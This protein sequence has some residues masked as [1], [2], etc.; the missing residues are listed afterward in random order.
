MTMV[1]ILIANFTIVQNQKY[2]TY[3]NAARGGLSHGHRTCTKKL[4][5]IGHMVPVICSQTD[6]HKQTDHST[7]L[8]YL[9]GVI[10]L[11]P[12]ITDGVVTDLCSRLRV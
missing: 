1:A 7:P 11:M 3:R 12:L 8:P 6:T 10:V 4:V 5:K 9:G 2:I